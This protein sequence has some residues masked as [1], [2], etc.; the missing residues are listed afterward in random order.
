MKFR[1]YDF[2][3]AYFLRSLKPRGRLNWVPRMPWNSENYLLKVWS[4]LH[5]RSSHAPKPVQ[6]KWRTTALQFQRKHR[7]RL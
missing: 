4:V 6:K 3:P 5:Y 7:K 2:D 1:P